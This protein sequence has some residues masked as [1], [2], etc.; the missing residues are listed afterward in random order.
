MY[1]TW[2]TYK[3]MKQILGVINESKNMANMSNDEK[4]VQKVSLLKISR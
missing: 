3:D 1:E 4:N 2:Y